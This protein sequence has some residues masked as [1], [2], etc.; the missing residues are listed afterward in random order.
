[1]STPAGEIQDAHREL[2]SALLSHLNQSVIQELVN[3][4]VEETGL[5]VG[6]IEIEFTDVS[7]ISGKEVKATGVRIRRE[8][9]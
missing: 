4:F 5:L 1:M 3:K 9:A 6:S 7:T 8:E 2:E